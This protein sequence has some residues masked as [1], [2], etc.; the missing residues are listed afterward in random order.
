MRHRL[1][2]ALA[3]ATTASAQEIRLT[4]GLV[5]ER[6]GRSGRTPVIHDLVTDVIDA[7]AVVSSVLPIAYEAPSFDSEPALDT[8][9]H[10]STGV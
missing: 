6:A 8:R 2:I 7:A 4:S 10:A 3:L 1:A 5:L 9:S